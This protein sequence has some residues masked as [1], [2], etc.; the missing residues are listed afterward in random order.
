MFSDHF[1]SQADRSGM[2]RAVLDSFRDL[3]THLL[4]SFFL[5]GRKRP[6]KPPAG[7]CAS[8]VAK[9][10]FSKSAAESYNHK[11]WMSAAKRVL[12]SKF[13]SRLMKA[14]DLSQS[15]TQI[16]FDEKSKC[17]ATDSSTQKNIAGSHGHA[18]R[19]P[20]IMH[21]TFNQKGVFSY[22]VSKPA[23]I[24]TGQCRPHSCKPRTNLEDLKVVSSCLSFQLICSALIY[25][26]LGPL[27]PII[28][29]ILILISSSS[30]SSTLSF[31]SPPLLSSTTSCLSCPTCFRILIPKYTTCHGP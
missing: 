23:P 4:D 26:V 13:A 10:H 20:S 28:I 12:Q 30:S 3:G 17:S 15:S 29:L 14:I 21:I 19:H 27:L 6:I 7:L 31:R 5:T 9:K 25:Q 16:L 8:Q 18:L 24:P 22:K 11:S 2:H 1:A